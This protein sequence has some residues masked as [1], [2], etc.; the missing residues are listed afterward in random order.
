MA[1]QPG[2]FDID[3]QLRRLSDL[4]DQLEA[5]AGAV[6]FEIFR[7][8]LEKALKYS[9]GARGGRPPFDPVLMMKILV[10]QAQ[11][12]LS[13]DR[14]EFLISDRLSF[15][16][17]L[18]LGLHDRVP[19]AKTIWAFRE[20][21]TKAGAITDLFK[22]FDEA[23]RDAGYIAMSG[24]LVDSTLVAAP[25]QRNTDDE[26]RQI[27]DGRT[28]DQI[29]PENPS[30]ARQK[31]TSAR[32]TV[33][34]GKARVREDGKPMADIAIPSFGYKAHTSI[35][36]KYRLIRRWEVTDAAAHDGRMLRR[37]LLD[38]SNTAS[39]VWADSAYRSRKN[40]AFMER[41]GF[42]SHVHRRK[43]KGKPMPAHIRRG[44]ATRSKHRAPI[45][46]VFAV[47]KQA[48][49]LTI[50]TIGIAR[51]K[52]KIGIANIVYN[53]RRLAQIQKA[54]GA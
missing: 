48:M 8:D 20:R 9:D 1:R 16:R 10:I 35:D 47:Q 17:F 3:E 32:W 33:Q 12:N 29:W 6:D 19:D 52:A 54:E 40:E 46:H 24:Q 30:K 49:S 36:R 39:G 15:M 7:S 51:A 42:T 26:K 43:P 34:F 45:E 50:R 31:D 23:L 18:G 21:L 11:N 28:A 37:G 2:F 53:I 22:R 27:R 25:K 5:Y 13:D 41:H 44:N 4:G 38:P 14:A